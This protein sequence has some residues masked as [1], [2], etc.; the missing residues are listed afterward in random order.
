MTVLKCIEWVWEREYQTGQESCMVAVW[1]SIFK[2]DSPLPGDCKDHRVEMWLCHFSSTQQPAHEE[3]LL[4]LYCSLVCLQAA[5]L[6]WKVKAACACSPEQHRLC[7]FGQ[8]WIIFPWYSSV[9]LGLLCVIP[10]RLSILVVKEGNKLKIV[11][12][13]SVGLKKGRHL[14][15]LLKSTC[16]LSLCVCECAS[17]STCL[18]SQEAPDLLTLELRWLWST[19]RWELNPGTVWG[20]ALNC[21][22]ISS[23]VILLCF[24]Y[25]PYIHLICSFILPISLISWIDKSALAAA[26]PAGC[27]KWLLERCGSA[28]VRVE[29]WK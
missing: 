16:D 29:R 25:L 20:S 8:L 10:L 5:Y 24:I 21:Q 19:T 13:I 23:T 26:G 6:M 11:K 14:C 9:V 12:C 22:A 7:S 1:V 28:V 27:R 15:F 2:S 17:V 4:S 18:S 3:S